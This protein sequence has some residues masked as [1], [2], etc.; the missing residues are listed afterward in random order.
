MFD[1]VLNM[2]RILNI[3][4]F[5]IYGGSEYTSVLN[6]LLVLNMSGF[7]IYHGSKDAIVTQGFEY[8]WMCLNNSWICLIIPMFLN[9]SEW[10][11]FYIY[12]VSFLI[13]RNHRSFSWKV[14]IWF[15]FYRS[16]KFFL[17]IY[18]S[19]LL[20]FFHFLELQRI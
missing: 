15:F 6:M 16:W 2:P 4:A 10:L 7:W 11:L 12:L 18:L 14:K 8:A 3:P 17:M 9:L 13:R 1:R 5:W 20:L 19:I